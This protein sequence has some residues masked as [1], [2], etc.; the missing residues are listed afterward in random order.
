M[1]HVFQTELSGASWPDKLICKDVTS[2]LMYIGMCIDCGICIILTSDVYLPRFTIVQDWDFG[3]MARSRQAM[4]AK[5]N[6]ASSMGSPQE[7]PEPC[8]Q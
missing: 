7:R 3:S 6:Q 5:Q 1:W 2:S 8:R 4:W